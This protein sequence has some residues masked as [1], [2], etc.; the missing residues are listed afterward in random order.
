LFSVG[1]LTQGWDVP[2]TTSWFRVLGFNVA[3]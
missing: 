1:K 3:P 2:G